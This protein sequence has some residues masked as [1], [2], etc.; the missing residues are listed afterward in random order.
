MNVIVSIIKKTIH[1]LFFSE[2]SK[3][4][5]QVEWYKCKMQYVAEIIEK[6]R[7]AGMSDDQIYNHIKY[8]VK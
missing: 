7:K 8:L 6:Y 2:E 3:T 4:S 1:F 5:P